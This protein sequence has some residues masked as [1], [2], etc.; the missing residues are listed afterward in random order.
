LAYDHVID[1]A[2]PA[3]QRRDRDYTVSRHFCRLLERTRID[4]IDVLNVYRRILR[5]HRAR[6]LEQSVRITFAIGVKV[7]G[8][9]QRT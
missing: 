2:G 1:E 5:E 9:A 7:L 3:D 4:E 6:C 8:S